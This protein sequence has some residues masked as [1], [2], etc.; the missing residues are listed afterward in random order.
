MSEV[1]IMGAVDSLKQIH[2]IGEYNVVL[3]AILL[4]I[5]I[6]CVIL[7]IQKIK[8]ALGLK[9]KSE[10]RKKEIDE[11][12]ENIEKRISKY[13]SRLNENADHFY[14]KQ[15]EYHEQS[16][17]I[18]NE[19]RDKQ[20]S[21][22][23]KQDGLIDSI[24]ELKRMFVQKNIDDMR[25]EILNFANAVMSSREY[26]KEQYDHVLDIYKQYESIL[27]ENKMQNGRV[28]TSIAFIKK[29]YEELMENGFKQ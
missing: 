11:R 25:W 12:F 16:I 5:L 24:S 14:N 23:D 28:D 17:T 21:L 18:R 22:S 29:H 20:D 19:L 26:N 4:V 27:A 1:G 3:S 13:E 6:T 2:E 10:I 8:D 15:K 9:T 7:G